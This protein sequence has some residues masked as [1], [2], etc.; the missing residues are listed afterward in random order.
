[1]TAICH[2]LHRPGRSRD[3]PGHL[4][5]WSRIFCRDPSTTILLLREFNPRTPLGRLL[6]RIANLTTPACNWSLTPHLG[7]IE[8]IS[9]T[10]LGLVS[11]VPRHALQQPYGCVLRHRR[12]QG[13]L[14]CCQ[15]IKSL[16]TAPTLDQ[17]RACDPVPGDGSSLQS[18]GL[19]PT[20]DFWYGMMHI[21]ALHD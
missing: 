16:N 20:A 5:Y 11:S 3:Q 15:L 19:S 21:G 10:A 6:H 18:P 12:G 4:C 17:L 14:N 9:F 13:F 1:M 7:G 2:A 8:H